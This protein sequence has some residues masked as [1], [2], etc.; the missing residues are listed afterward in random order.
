MKTEGLAGDA[1]A[2]DD[3]ANVGD[4]KYSMKGFV[5]FFGMLFR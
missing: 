4:C 2:R 3:L 1:I 5:V